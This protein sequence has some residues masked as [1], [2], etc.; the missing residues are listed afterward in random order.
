MQFLV[1]GAT[2]TAEVATM[3]GFGAHVPELSLGV[4]SPIAEIW[5]CRAQVSQE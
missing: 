5:V 3:S 4:W 1:V 2:P